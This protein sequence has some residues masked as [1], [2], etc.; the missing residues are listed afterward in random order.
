[1]HQV[2]ITGAAAYLPNEAVGNEEMEA[3]LGEIN[4]EPSIYRSAV[5]KRNGIKQRYYAFREGRQTHLNEELAANAVNDLLASK[6]MSMDRIEMLAAGTTL[7]DVLLPGFASMVHGRLGGQPMEV[8]T[9]AGICCASMIAFKAAYNALRCGDHHNA[10]AV[11]SE[12]SSAM[13]KA[14]RFERESEIEDQRETGDNSS[15]KFLKADFLRWMLSDGA[16]AWL[17]ETHPRPDQLSLR[18][19]WVRLCSFANNYPTCMYMGT[20]NTRNLSPSDSYLH[21]DTF[22]QAEAEGLMIV[23]QDTRVLPVGLKGSIVGHAA[24]LRD[25]GLL[26]PDEIDH[27]LVHISSMGLLDPLNEQA[28]QAGINIPRDR[29]FANLTTK[30]NTGAASIFIILEEAL[31]TGLFKEGEQILIMVPESGRFMSCYVHLTCVAN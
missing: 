16:G 10:I 26:M 12:L 18:I 2:Y 14:S 21:Y 7:A 23:R 28:V 27:F 30:G 19:D 3:V 5:L 15:F 9:G 25:E 31:N 1:M 22:S 17:L 8:V 6:N 13:M 29:W 20:S 24:K 11:G 4:N